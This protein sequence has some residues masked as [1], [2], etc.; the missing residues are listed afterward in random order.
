MISMA[1]V[2]VEIDGDVYVYA[3][4]GED[5]ELADFIAEV[6]NNVPDAEAEVV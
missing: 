4:S 1:S 2:K 3:L 6:V 5:E